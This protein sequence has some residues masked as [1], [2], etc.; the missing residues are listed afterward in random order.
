MFEVVVVWVLTPSNCV[1]GYHCCGRSWCH[2][3]QGEVLTT[4]LY[5]VR[6]QKTIT[7]IF[8][9]VKLVCCSHYFYLLLNAEMKFM[10]WTAGHN[11][12]SH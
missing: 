9:A 8:I 6:N 11:L 10:R 12:L 4:S 2:H 1:V 5:G 7:W 3:V